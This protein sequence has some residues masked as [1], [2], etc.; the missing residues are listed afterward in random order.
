MW[1]SWNGKNS[2]HHYDHLTRCSNHK[3]LEIH[4]GETH[5]HGSN[6]MPFKI[7][8]AVAH[9]FIACPVLHDHPGILE[10]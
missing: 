9:S 1:E 8:T 10:R 4:G 6:V 3:V 2:G 5:M 7:P